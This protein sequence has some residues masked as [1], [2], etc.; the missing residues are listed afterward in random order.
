MRKAGLRFGPQLRNDGL[1]KNL[2]KFNTLLIERIDVPDYALGE[3]G[4]LLECHELA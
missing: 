2:T 3:H 4:M 1:G